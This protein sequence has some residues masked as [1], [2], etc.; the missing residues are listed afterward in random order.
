ML[1][2][3]P[4]NIVDIMRYLLTLQIAEYYFILIES[5]NGLRMAMNKTK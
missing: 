4:F 5:V 2:E 3:F 1:L